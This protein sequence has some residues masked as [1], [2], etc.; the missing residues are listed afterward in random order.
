MNDNDPS[1]LRNMHEDLP[2]VVVTPLVGEVKAGASDPSQAETVS[3]LANKPEAPVQTV[4]APPLGEVMAGA[5]NDKDVPPS[6]LGTSYAPP[7]P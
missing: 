4:A 3:V 7:A 1:I 2:P 6:L 5:S